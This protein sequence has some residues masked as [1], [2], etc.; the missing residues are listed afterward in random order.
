LETIPS[1]D[2]SII[3]ELARQQLELA[4]TPQNKNLEREWLAHNTFKG[5]R[6]MIHLEL[7]TFEQDVILPLLRCKTER[8]REIEAEL[9]RQFLNMELFKDDRPTPCYF[10]LRIRT[11]FTLF[12][13][14]IRKF[15]VP[16]T[17]GNK[18]GHSFHGIVGDL[19][20]DYHKLGAS[21]YGVDRKYSQRE[22]DY[23]NELFGDILPVRRVSDALYAVPTQKIVHLMG[24]E[25]M[26]CSMAAY[27]ELFLEMMDRVADDYISYF[28]FLES[29]G[30]LKPTTGAQ[31]LHQGSFC[32]TDELPTKIPEGRPLSTNEV[33]GFL[34]SQESAGISPNMFGEL[35][36]PC[37]KKIAAVYGAL[38]YGCCESVSVVWDYLKYLPN[39]KKIS[40]SPWCDE[41]AMGERLRGKKV[42]YHRKP[43]PNYLGVGNSLDEDALRSHF[44]TTLRAAQ[45]CKLEFTQ[46]D[47]YT[48]NGDVAKAQ[49]YVQ[50]LRETIEENWMV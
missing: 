21:E 28:R 40:I 24:M 44:K 3:R 41:E 34:D 39:L 14:E 42:I 12:G 16:D 1:N 10:P 50:I 20:D 7:W 8:A 17:Q 5:N 4:N 23:L 6:P 25:N 30:L 36:F 31:Q 18:L 45:G 35:V 2:K 19:K 46:R 15:H 48:L 11:W 37:Y 49:R 38:S 27:P 33:W 29:E 43:S 32:Y 47:V 13:H 26:Y 9:Y 22:E